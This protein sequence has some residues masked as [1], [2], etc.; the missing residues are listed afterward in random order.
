M[1][2]PGSASDASRATFRFAIE[3]GL[4]HSAPFLSLLLVRDLP[5]HQPVKRNGATD[6]VGSHTSRNSPDEGEA[7][8]LA[9]IGCA[10]LL[11]PT[12]ADDL[13]KLL[14]PDS[15]EHAVNPN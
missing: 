10:A 12:V 9:A 15:L 5:Q 11:M 4:A 14:Q 8:A 1:T 3:D 2:G 13:T 7:F 6:T